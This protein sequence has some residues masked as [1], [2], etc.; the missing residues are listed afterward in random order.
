[1]EGITN[2]M[3]KINLD[4][5]EPADFVPKTIKNVP[6]RPTTKQYLDAQKS[7]ITIAEMVHGTSFITRYAEVTGRIASI[8][9][10]NKELVQPLIDLL[11]TSTDIRKSKPP[12]VKRDNSNNYYTRVFDVTSEYEALI[13]L[14]P[15]VDHLGL[16][17][18]FRTKVTVPTTKSLLKK[19]F[20]LPDANKE[21]FTEAT[22]IA[23][24]E[25]TD[26]IH[27]SNKDLDQVVKQVINFVP[28]N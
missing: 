18:D 25:D 6:L 24:P 2:K 3:H 14:I 20:D 27:I 15:N 1:M 19:Y 13:D 16:R 8:D 22:G 7:V 21:G 26:I 5:P 23:L 28:K 12:K 4:N 9:T 10:I 11:N 17:E